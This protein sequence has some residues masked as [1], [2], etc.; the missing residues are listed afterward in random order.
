[1]AAVRHLGIVLPPYE[2]THEVCCWPQ[3]PVKFHV[4]LMHRSIAIWIFSIWFELPIQDPKMG[5][6]G[7]VGPL[8]VIIHH[9]D[10]RKGT[11][12]R[13]SASFKLSTVKIRWEVW[14]VGELSENV[15]DTQTHTQVN[16]RLYNSHNHDF[17]PISRFISELMQDRAMVTME[18]N[19]KPHPSFWMV[20][21]WMILS[22]L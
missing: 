12:L 1:M 22:D 21:V 20:P 9:R 3:L 16:I 11:S 17:R 7:D 4:N 8:N 18:A 13:K 14:P 6:L 19:R 10:P 2:T 5:V 15:T